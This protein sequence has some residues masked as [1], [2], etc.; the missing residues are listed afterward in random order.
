VDHLL[1]PVTKKEGIYVEVQISWGSDI[2]QTQGLPY[3][4]PLQ[5]GGLISFS[6]KGEVGGITSA[7]RVILEN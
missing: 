5:L 6:V 1:L 2:R 7:F 4:A 3:T